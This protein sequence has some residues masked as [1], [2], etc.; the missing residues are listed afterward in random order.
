MNLG[1]FSPLPRSKAN[2]DHVS[3]ILQNHTKSSQIFWVL[4]LMSPNT[5][6]IPNNANW[7]PRKSILCY[8]KSLL[9][10]SSAIRKV[11][12]W[13]WSWY[14]IFKWMQCQFIMIIKF[15]TCINTNIFQ[16]VM[17]FCKWM[18]F[19][20]FHSCLILLYLHDACNWYCSSM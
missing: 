12:P 4:P 3:Q 20:W 7:N 18:I 10:R 6:G 16:V 1:S 13:H 15:I 8:R 11:F 19:L 9:S 5:N 14:S 17:V 2:L